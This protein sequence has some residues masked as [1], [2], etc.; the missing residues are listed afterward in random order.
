MGLVARGSEP[1]PL[2]RHLCPC[3]ASGCTK[4]MET[5]RSSAECTVMTAFQYLDPYGTC[6][7]TRVR[8]MSAPGPDHFGMAAA[9]TSGRPP[10]TLSTRT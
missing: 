6:A 1:T 8:S 3:I 7:A 5:T 2:P 4:T 10:L 9:G